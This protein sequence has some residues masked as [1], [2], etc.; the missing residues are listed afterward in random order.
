MYDFLVDTHT[1]L[2]AKEFAND[3][4]QVIRRA[5]DAKVKYFILPAIDSSEFDAMML[6]AK[7]FPLQCFPTIGLHPTS[8]RK[9]YEKELDFVKQQLN[10]DLFV[11]IGEIGID[12]YWSLEFIEQQRYVFREQL[13]LAAECGLPVIIHSRNSFNEI[14]P[15]VRELKGQLKGI[16]HSFSGTLEDY[17]VIK[18][19]GGFKL[20]VGGVLTFKNSNL[21]GLV[22]QIP[23]DDIVLETDS[24]YLTPAPHRGKRNESVYVVLVAERL[25]EIKNMDIAEVVDRTTRNALSVFSL[26]N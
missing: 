1:H 12:C 13:R 8:V 25:A 2:F 5:E 10:S 21:P 6:L 16:F 19:L 20:G 3:I 4:D 23:I 7:R 24:P 14:F 15:I 22:K 18:D 26:K 17:H 9:N 11:G